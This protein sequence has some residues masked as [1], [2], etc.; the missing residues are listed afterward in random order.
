M[1]TWSESALGSEEPNGLAWAVILGFLRVTTHPRV[2]AKPLDPADASD[3][4]RAPGTAR[5]CARCDAVSSDSDFARFPA[6]RG[7]NPVGE[8]LR[9]RPNRRASPEAQRS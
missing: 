5:D 3:D 7:E 9:T 2:F 6:P 4:R 8:S 1:R